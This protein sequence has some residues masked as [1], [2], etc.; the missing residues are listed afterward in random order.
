M[1]GKKRAVVDAENLLKVMRLVPLFVE[2]LVDEHMGA[3]AMKEGLDGREIHGP[4]VRKLER[5]D[6]EIHRLLGGQRAE[7]MEP[8]AEKSGLSCSKVRK[9]FFQTLE[10]SHRGNEGKEGRK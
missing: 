6:A 1:F 7:S 4:A 3:H 10:G 8:G 2:A 5:I 9:I